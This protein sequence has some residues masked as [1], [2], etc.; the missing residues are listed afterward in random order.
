MIELQD[1]EGNLSALE[2]DV[3]L[4][5]Y[6]KQGSAQPVSHYDSDAYQRVTFLAGET[7]KS[8]DIS[9]THSDADK[10]FQVGTRYGLNVA[11]SSPETLTIKAKEQTPVVPPVTPDTGNSSGGGSLGFISLLLL[12]GFSFKRKTNV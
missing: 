2:H 4:E 1:S 6:T 3:S 12:L 10:A 5:F 9:V 8:V 7:Q 11:E